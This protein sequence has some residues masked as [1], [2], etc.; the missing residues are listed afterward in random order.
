MNDDQLTSV[1]YRAKETEETE[2]EGE[3]QEKDEEQ[4]EGPKPAPVSA[5]M[6]QRL[7]REDRLL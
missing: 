2:K 7:R 3:E 1:S 5:L 4:E 6:K